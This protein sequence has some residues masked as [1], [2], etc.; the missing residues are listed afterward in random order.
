MFTVNLLRASGTTKIKNLD[1]NIGSL[2][3]K[4]T[5]E[6]L[7]EISD[8]VPTEEVAG[9]RYPDALDKT[10]WNFATTPRRDC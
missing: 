4:L 1:D 10:S 8:A 5:K 2:T 9:D 6:D 3:V 7:K